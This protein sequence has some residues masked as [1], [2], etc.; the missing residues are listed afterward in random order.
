MVI[1]RMIESAETEFK[2][3]LTRFCQDEAEGALTPES[4]HAI[5]RGIQRALAATGRAT[6]W[7]PGARPF[8]S[9]TGRKNA[10]RRRGA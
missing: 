7:R 1:E 9:S 10:S 2:E 4:A 3:N 5:T 8:G 6:R